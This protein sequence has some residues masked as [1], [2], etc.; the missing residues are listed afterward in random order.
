MIIRRWSGTRWGSKL[1][2]VVRFTRVTP[3]N[4]VS[5]SFSLI[6]CNIAVHSLWL[7]PQSI[8]VCARSCVFVLALRRPPATI[9]LC[10]LIFFHSILYLLLPPCLFNRSLFNQE[11]CCWCC[12]SLT[13]MRL[14]YCCCWSKVQVKKVRITIIIVA[15]MAP[16]TGW[17]QCTTLD[18]STHTRSYCLLADDWINGR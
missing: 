7:C 5:L 6:S 1:S 16:T 4:R 14:G 18:G 3:K 17:A 13:R 11:Q 10:V 9:Q 15:L 12:C 2:K 8:R